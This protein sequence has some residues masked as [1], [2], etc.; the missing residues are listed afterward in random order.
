MR[1]FWT[2]FFLGSMLLVGVDVMEQRHSPRLSSETSTPEM[3]IAGDALGVPTP[4][5][6]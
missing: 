3:S 2:I 6:E 5:P 1:A 4:R